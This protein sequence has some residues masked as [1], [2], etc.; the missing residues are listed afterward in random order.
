MTHQITEAI[1]K[2]GK[3]PEDKI[4]LMQEKV[5][6]FERLKDQIILNQGL[7]SQ[8]VY[9]LISGAMMQYRLNEEMEMEVFDL[10]IAGDWVI[11]RESFTA[12][13][14]SN[15]ILKAYS[16]CTYFELSLHAIHQLI[17]QSQQFLQLASVLATSNINA[18]LS[19]LTTPIDKYKCLIKHKP[20]LINEFPLKLIAS[21]LKITPESLSRARKKL[22]QRQS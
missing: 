18:E 13:K 8:S 16:D 11:C 19:L 22:S 4:A 15:Y 1:Q 3:F 7:T 14:P 17:A 5:V 9:Y 21:Y 20:L 10:H 6:L 2:I 12:Q